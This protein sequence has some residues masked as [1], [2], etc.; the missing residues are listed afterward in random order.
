LFNI[1]RGNR[2]RAI[3]LKTGVKAAVTAGNNAFLTV[4]DYIVNNL[5]VMRGTNKLIRRY[6]DMFDL[7]A[8]T[9]EAYAI[10]P[11]TGRG[12]IDFC[13]HGV[14]DEIF[15]LRSMVAGPTGDVD[16]FL[17]GDVI[18]AAG[19]AAVVVWEEWRGFPYRTPAK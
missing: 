6:N 13:E 8:E 18:G 11:D 9:R 5:L 19:Q 17:Q 7:A 1:P 10:Q 12:L 4:S 3:L 16:T 14:E 15:D 2:L